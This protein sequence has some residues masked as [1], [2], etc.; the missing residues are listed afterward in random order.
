[1]WSRNNLAR[2]ASKYL[3]SATG[4]LSEGAQL[5]TT[6]E[7]LGVEFHTPSNSILEDVQ[8]QQTGSLEPLSFVNAMYLATDGAMHDNRLGCGVLLWHP[9]IGIFWTASFRFV[10]ATPTS[11]DGEWAARLHGLHWLAGW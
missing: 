5:K 1:M 6:A 4:S 9:T 10:V 7:Q 8:V 2:A 3:L 11:T